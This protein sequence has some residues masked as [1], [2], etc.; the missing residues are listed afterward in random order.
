[1]PAPGGMCSPGSTRY[2]ALASA[3][4]ALTGRL[5]RL[6]VCVFSQGE[7]FQGRDTMVT[8][9]FGDLGGF[10]ADDATSSTSRDDYVER[11]FA[12]GMP[13]ALSRRSAIARA[14]WFD[15]YTALALERDVRE[16]SKIRQGML[17]PQSVSS[18]TVA[19]A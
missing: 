2:D 16:I 7:R 9:L 8:G 11:A 18:A 14:R 19:R 10:V 13:M 15:E 1:M 5:T 4:Q 17:L 3:A 12:G 6:R